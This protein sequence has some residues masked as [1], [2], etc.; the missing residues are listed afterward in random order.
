MKYLIEDTEKHTMGEINFY[1]VN[2]LMKTSLNEDDIVIDEALKVKV[3]MMELERIFDENDM[4]E[5]YEMDLGCMHLKKTGNTIE[6]TKNEIKSRFEDA[7]RCMLI[8]CK[9]S[10]K[11]TNNK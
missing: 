8:G 4:S 9:E 11:P 5:F 3:A 1:F 6:F 7:Y 10:I 2:E